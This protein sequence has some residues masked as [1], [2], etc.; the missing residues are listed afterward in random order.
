MTRDIPQI[1]MIDLSIVVMLADG[2]S[3]SQVGDQVG[4]SPS[5]LSHR[6]TR[7]SDRVGYPVT[8]TVGRQLRISDRM[9]RS[10]PHL[11]AA[12]Q[13]LVKAQSIVDQ[14]LGT[15]RSM[16][17]ARIFSGWAEQFLPDDSGVDQWQVVTGTSED[18]VRYVR[19]GHVE[20][21]MIRTDHGLAGMNMRILGYD[22]LMA[23]ASP[24]LV[25]KLPDAMELWPWIGF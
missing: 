1:D 24:A 13:H 23:V 20:A 2:A 16:G 14:D 8:Q 7:L 18:I 9:A 6:L 22:P 17:I 12:L 5:A 19:Q 11:K 4:L 15:V 25:H 21:G 3:L 10:I